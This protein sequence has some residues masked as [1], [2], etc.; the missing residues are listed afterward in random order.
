MDPVPP[1]Q[2]AWC[3]LLAERG[4]HS[5]IVARLWVVLGE[6][7]GLPPVGAGETDAAALFARL[8]AALVAHYPYAFPRQAA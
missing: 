5:A 7:T 8:R 3:H 4:L 1:R 2:A 6:V